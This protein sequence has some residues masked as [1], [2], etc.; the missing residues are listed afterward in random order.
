MLIWGAGV[1]PEF[2]EMLVL[3]MLPTIPTGETGF[4]DKFDDTVLLIVD[5]KM[6]K[7]VFVTL[8]V[9]NKLLVKLINCD[10]VVLKTLLKVVFIEELLFA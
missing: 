4:D 3:V 6:L 2:V 8:F 5:E 1:I 7:V 10:R 9:F